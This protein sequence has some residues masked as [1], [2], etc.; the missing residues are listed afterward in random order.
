M[1]LLGKKDFPGIIG[2]LGKTWSLPRLH[3]SIT[4]ITVGPVTTKAWQISK[5]SEAVIKRSPSN[6]TFNI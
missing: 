3:S 4:W 2:I 1:F 6:F 5:Q